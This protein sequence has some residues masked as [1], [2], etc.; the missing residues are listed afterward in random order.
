LTGRRST[1]HDGRDADKERSDMQH[2]VPICLIEDDCETREAVRMIFADE[3]YRITEARDAAI[4][5]DLLL[6]SPAALVVLLDHKL[7]EMLGCDR[8]ELVLRDPRLQRHRYI[9]LTAVHPTELAR[10]CGACSNVSRFPSSPSHLT[11]TACSMWCRRQKSGYGPM[12][13]ILTRCPSTGSPPR[14]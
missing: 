12:R 14:T 11:L 1:A 3:G 2:K 7:P 8:L 10:D 13:A 6:H 5:Y 4:G 9:Y